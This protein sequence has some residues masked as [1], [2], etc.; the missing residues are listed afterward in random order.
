MTKLEECFTCK[1]RENIQGDAHIKCTNPDKTMIGSPHG[2]RFGWFNY[3]NNFDPI[4][5]EK[6]CSTYSNK[7]R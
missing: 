3:P 7:N 5:K 6:K 4:W 2:I 1:Y